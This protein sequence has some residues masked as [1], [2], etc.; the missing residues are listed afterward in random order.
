[1]PIRPALPAGP[2]LA[3][4]LLA[5]LLA[6]ASAPVRSQTIDYG[7]L[8]TLF[9]E[10]VT[11]SATGKPQRS[12]EVPAT[13]EII[14]AAQIARSGAP[15]LPTVLRDLAGLDVTTAGS[16]AA[17]VSIRGYVRPMSGR[18][19]VL[20]DGRQIYNDSFG[21]VSWGLL[22]VEL[23]S[24]RQVE[25]VKG[26]QSALY[27]FN[28]AAGV[29]NIITRDPLDDPTNFAR[30]RAGSGRHR[31]ASAAATAKLGEHTAV[32]LSGGGFQAGRGPGF[33]SQAGEPLSNLEPTRRAL[34]A[35]AVTRFEDG[36]RL[37]LGLGHVG[38]T[39]VR[40]HPGFAPLEQR[41]E[42]TAI[43]GAYSRETPLGLVT[44]QAYHNRFVT[45]STLEDFGRDTARN[46]AT[47]ASVQDLFKLGADDSFRLSLEY[48]HNQSSVFGNSA[49]SLAYQVGSAS[50]MWDRALGDSVSLVNAL[51]FDHL[52]LERSGPIS[53]DTPREEN[54]FRRSI[55]ALSF[56]S[57][58][59]W[60]ATADDTLRLTAGRGLNLPTL[61][62]LGA[63]ELRSA[64]TFLL[65]YGNPRLEPAEVWNYELSWDHA[66]PALEAGLRT[67][68][69]Y[70]EN[71]QLIDFDRSFSL[72][73]LTGLPRFSQ[74]NYGSSQTLGLELGLN[75]RL[76]PAWSW[77]ANYTL[78]TI[79]DQLPE[80]SPLIFPE[81]GY[82]GNSPRH[83]IN[84]RL[85]WTGDPWEADLALHWL[86][87]YSMPDVSGWSLGDTRTR[88]EL[89]NALILEPRLGLRLT[90]SVTAEVAAQGLW[91]RREQPVSLVEQRVLFSIIG[92]W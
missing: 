35:D 14:T 34:N 24:I 46:S 75:G 44:A 9:N 47:V 13:M 52:Q 45:D 16:N 78:Q 73:P 27:G 79:R 3:L 62:E 7:A 28:A 66:L 11:V 17:D 64:R 90:D 63:L 74:I 76:A 40:L 54:D 84:L 65:D 49:A 67:S 81:V 88:A 68:V 22:P 23:D 50:A 77:Q 4:R 26:P 51:R 60:R 59:V 69:F 41:Q 12:S 18:L 58:L 85:G 89:G 86:S 92:R 87:Q 56:N 82:A 43:K 53:F 55:N 8:E 2:G 31:Q 15:D 30:V 5:L 71:R 29:I 70:Q 83:K 37:S 39:E 48:R 32:R 25:V 20:V 38:G 19:L 36:S 33:A 57:G 72:S 80:R 91:D 21:F 6:T 10:P 1:M 42:V 61:A